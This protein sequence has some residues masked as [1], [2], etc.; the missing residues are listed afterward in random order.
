MTQPDTQ[1]TPHIIPIEAIRKLLSKPGSVMALCRLLGFEQS[2]L[3]RHLHK[4][5]PM[6]IERQV[7][8]VAVLRFSTFLSKSRD[9]R[10]KRT[11]P[12]T[13]DD[14]KLEW[15]THGSG[16]GK[17]NVSHGGPAHGSVAD[18]ASRDPP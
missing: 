7:A 17:G 1:P 5:V 2:T 10:K 4:G 9:S 6:P 14:L 15:L 13:L 11:K 12:F 3:Y 18:R 16:S 8:I